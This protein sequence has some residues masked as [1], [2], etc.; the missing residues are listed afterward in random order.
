MTEWLPIPGFDGYEVSSDGQVVSL[1]RGRRTTLAQHIDACGYF[2][3]GI[4]RN[5]ERINKRVHQLVADSFMGSRPDG[6]VIRHIDGDHRNNT[7]GNL[8]WGSQSEN[9][10]DSVAHG[11]QRNIRKT[12]CPRGHAYTDV[13]TTYESK[14]N[15]KCRTCR[16]EAERLR[17]AKRRTS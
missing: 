4:Y 9:V 1:R 14:G 3:L 5:G 16:R 17:R 6:A 11:T 10:C 15:R 12:H 7:V 8:C 2:R 13:N